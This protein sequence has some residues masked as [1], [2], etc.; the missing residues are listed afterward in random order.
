MLEAEPNFQNAKEI[1]KENEKIRE[2]L[3]E[4]NSELSK[5]VEHTSIANL[6]PK[7]HVEF[8]YKSLEEKHKIISRELNNNE[9]I[10]ETTYEEYQKLKNRLNTIKSPEYV[11]DLEEK[12]AETQK[13]IE[14]IKRTNLKLNLQSVASG[15]DLH[16]IENDGMPATI[17]EANDKATELAILKRKI[18][19]LIEKNEKLELEREKKTEDYERVKEKYEK[20][21]AI[22]EALKLGNDNSKRIERYNT[23]KK[24]VDI[25]EEAV[26]N[27]EN[28]NQ[29]YMDNYLFRELE[30]LMIAQERDREHIKKLEEMIEQQK[31]ALKE[32]IEKEGLKDKNDKLTREVVR[33]IE[34]SLEAANT[35]LPSDVSIIGLNSAK[36][37]DAKKPS[38]PP[39]AK[40]AK[41][42]IYEGLPLFSP[43]KL[44][45]EEAPQK[46]ILIRKTELFAERKSPKHGEKEYRES[47][48][49]VEKRENKFGFKSEKRTEKEDTS[50]G[51][52]TSRKTPDQKERPR[53]VE[54]EKPKEEVNPA[55]SKPNLF[56]KPFGRKADHSEESS[57]KLDENKKPEITQNNPKEQVFDPIGNKKQEPLTLPD[58][59]GKKP[60]EPQNNEPLRLSE[61]F[62]PKKR[63]DGLGLNNNTNNQPLQLSGNQKLSDNYKLTTDIPV[64]ESIQLGG[65]SRLNK[66][67][68]RQDNNTSN[69]DDLFNASTSL[70]LSDN[71]V[72]NTINQNKGKDIIDPFAKFDNLDNLDF[73]NKRIGE[74]EKKPANNFENVGLFNPTEEPTIKN[75]SANNQP[76]NMNI[77]LFAPDDLDSAFSKAQTKRGPRDR[78]TNTDDIFGE[79]KK[80]EKTD[81]IDFSIK[82]TS[83]RIGNKP[84]KINAFNIGGGDDD[85]FSNNKKEEPFTLTK[86]NTAEKSLTFDKPIDFTVNKKNDDIFD[87]KLDDM[88]DKKVDDIFGKPKAEE[89][90]SLAPS[91]NDDAIGGKPRRMKIGVKD[92]SEKVKNLFY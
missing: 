19:K 30:E 33:K 34:L 17:K 48:P 16:D 88:F 51:K 37:K 78:V 26:K 58:T 22:A 85:L 20:L 91:N 50:V 1:E 25:M 47:S 38:K 55:F 74:P 2:Y 66:G 35:N 70:K 60:T 89:K 77:G 59:F 41:K 45:K 56:K 75:K 28:K 79:P 54:Q 4:L 92:K 86:T 27:T 14:Q 73:S 61:E 84:K 23:L 49:S 82:E 63:N 24:Q 72:N 68:R 90:F 44:K 76:T 31:Q 67:R 53:E 11:I 39:L 62:Q 3:K 5:V 6:A 40:D 8:K 69:N 80:E 7:K 42:D 29:K 21:T 65:V 12:I 57:M 36:N 18:E 83:V 71:N 15:K 64:D 13:K 87:K 43:S 10:L 46:K 81:K 32:I 9:K 52:L